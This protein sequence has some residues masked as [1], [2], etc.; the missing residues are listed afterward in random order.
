[1]KDISDQNW[2]AMADFSNFVTEA[3]DKSVLTPPEVIAVLEMIL[4][5]LKQLLEF[6]K[7]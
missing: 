2:V 3:I 4:G 6:K 5:R 7:A 1:M